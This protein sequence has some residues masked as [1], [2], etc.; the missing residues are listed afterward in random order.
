MQIGEMCFENNWAAQR[1][2]EIRRD[3]SKALSSTSVEDLASDI[4]WGFTDEDI[5]ELAWL[6][7]NLMHR[8]K[9]EQLLIECNFISIAFDLREGRYIEYF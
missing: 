3:W 4:G 2:G 7:K 8:K 6:H 5:K 1:D 9:I